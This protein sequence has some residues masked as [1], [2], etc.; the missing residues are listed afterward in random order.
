MW[1]LRYTTKF[2]ASCHHAD[3]SWTTYEEKSNFR[4]VELVKLALYVVVF[5]RGSISFVLYFYVSTILYDFGTIFQGRKIL[6]HGEWKKSNYVCLEL[7]N[8]TLLKWEM[9]KIAKA[10]FFLWRETNTLS[11]GL[12]IEYWSYIISIYVGIYYP[13]PSKNNVNVIIT[14]ISTTCAILVTIKW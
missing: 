13:Y 3:D 11:Y 1:V 6:L 7:L 9:R 4:F 10:K 2:V 8:L 5:G 12:G 14:H